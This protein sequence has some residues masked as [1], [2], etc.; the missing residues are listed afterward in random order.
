MFYNRVNHFQNYMLTWTTNILSARNVWISLDRPP[1]PKEP[2]ELGK[3]VNPRPR[4]M[5]DAIAYRK[6]AVSFFVQ[7]DSI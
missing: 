2:M 5:I 6:W 1:P 7:V 3:A 4:T